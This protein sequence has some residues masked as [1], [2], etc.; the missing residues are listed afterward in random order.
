MSRMLYE[1]SSYN[2]NHVRPDSQGTRHDDR[3]KQ[4]LHKN[5]ETIPFIPLHP[6]ILSKYYPIHHVRYPSKKVSRH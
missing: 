2:R 5:P 4:D 1:T 3:I 6:V